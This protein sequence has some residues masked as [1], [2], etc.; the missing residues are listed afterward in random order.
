MEVF[1]WSENYTRFVFSP[2]RMSP[3]GERRWGGVTCGGR[4]EHRKRSLG[5]EY[6]AWV[7]GSI[8]SR[9]IHGRRTALLHAGAG[10][11]GGSHYV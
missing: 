9:D 6:H 3:L 5:R 10:L 7:N 1:F 11:R 4:E 2:G 8:D